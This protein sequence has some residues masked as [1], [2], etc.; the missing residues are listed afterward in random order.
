ML[1][2][3]FLTVIVI[4]VPAALQD[5]RALQWPDQCQSEWSH[6]RVIRSF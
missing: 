6:Y 4:S 5:L 1:L 2:Q 3:P